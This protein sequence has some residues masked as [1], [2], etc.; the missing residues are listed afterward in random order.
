MTGIIMYR[1]IS[2]RQAPHTFFLGP[3]YPS[4]ENQIEI[5]IPSRYSCADEN[6]VLYQEF[7]KT[8]NPEQ[9]DCVILNDN[10]ASIEPVLELPWS[11]FTSLMHL[12]YSRNKVMNLSFLR[13]IP[14]LRHL[15]LQAYSENSVDLEGIEECA[16]LESLNISGTITSIRG[17]EHCQQLEDVRLTIDISA[18]LALLGHLQ[19]L[20][21]LDIA[22]H[23]FDCRFIEPLLNL[24]NL[25][26]RSSRAS[27]LECIGRL[28]QLTKLKLDIWTKEEL[29]IRDTPLVSLKLRGRYKKIVLDSLPLLAC[30]W[31]SKDEF[32]SLE[33]ILISNL[34]NCPVFS[35]V[36]QSKPFR[37]CL[38]RN[39]PLLEDLYLGFSGI[40]RSRKKPSGLVRISNCQTLQYIC[41]SS[42]EEPHILGSLSIKKCPM[43]VECVLCSIGLNSLKQ[44]DI[45]PVCLNVSGNHLTSLRHLDTSRLKEITISHN[46]ILTLNELRGCELNSFGANGCDIISFSPL[47][48]NLPSLVSLSIKNGWICSK[49]DHQEFVRLAQ[50]QGLKWNRDQ[51]EAMPEMEW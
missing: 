5:M 46:P 8:N 32:L 36:V 34:P 9:I 24:T 42:R 22:R 7:I 20:K 10:N 29:V 23:E 12:V 40:D 33:T 47:I 15:H 27:N 43:V 3:K 48:P 2:H 30:N 50:R 44:L 13:Q 38:V 21:V 19:N 31:C 49:R 37:E 25:T 26:I 41:V 39:C 45:R 35:L 17:L 11:R 4:S 6:H 28:P 1:L 18:E 51:T 16:C 14:L